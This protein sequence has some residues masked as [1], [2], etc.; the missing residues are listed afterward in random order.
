LSDLGV[1]QA[2]LEA[3]NEQLPVWQVK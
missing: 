1:T 2:M 3:A